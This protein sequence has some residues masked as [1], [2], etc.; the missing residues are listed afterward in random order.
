MDEEHQDAF[1]D[2]IWE[3]QMRLSGALNSQV[4]D[5][6]IHF[7]VLVVCAVS[8]AVAVVQ[9]VETFDPHTWQSISVLVSTPQTPVDTCNHFCL[10]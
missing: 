9:L 1:R 2:L 4:Q 6:W 8:V 5:I 10:R 3:Y 7:A